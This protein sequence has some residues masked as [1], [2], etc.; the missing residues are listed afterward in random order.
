[1]R[2]KDEMIDFLSSAQGKLQMVLL[3]LCIIGLIC[4]CTW[5]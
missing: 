5:L 2:F 4:L 1:M 3:G